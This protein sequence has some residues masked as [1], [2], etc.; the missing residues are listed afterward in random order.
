VGI[1]KTHWTEAGDIKEGDFRI[2]SSGGE[3]LGEDSLVTARFRTGAEYMTVCQVYAPTSSVSDI[4]MNAF[5]DQLQGVLN[6]VPSSD[7]I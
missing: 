6:S 1:S 5:N 7:A 4:E 3:D 2:I